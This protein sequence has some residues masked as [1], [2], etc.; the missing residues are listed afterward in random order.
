MNEMSCIYKLI[1][2]W[3]WVE[4]PRFLLKSVG[5]KQQKVVILRR[6]TRDALLATIGLDLKSNL[7]V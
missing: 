7:R 3:V 2:K 5:E 1:F 6:R 4:R